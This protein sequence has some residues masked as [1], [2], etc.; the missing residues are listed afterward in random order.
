MMD[1][2][3]NQTKVSIVI[4]VRNAVDTIENTIKS[5]LNQDY[6]NFELVILDGISTDG[7]LA[8]IEKYKNDISYFKSEKDNG[9]YDA[10]NNSIEHCTG[11]YIYFIGADDELYSKT[12]LS[13]IF[14]NPLINDEIIYG[15]AFYIKRKKIRFGKINRY[16]LSKHNFNHQTI[17]YPKSVFKSYSYETKYT[18]W[19]DYYL[20]IILFF[21]AKYKFV[22]V[23]IIVSKFN[24][25][26]TSGINNLDLSFEKDKK[27]IMSDIFP[28]DV[29]AFHIAR[30]LFLFLQCKFKKLLWIM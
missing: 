13:N 30:R 4:V 17:F 8:I 6:K 2:S 21:K 26:G 19:A 18:I 20:N 24:D 25:L 16:H 22:Y 14:K 1:V 5:I 3:I 27:K 28:F 15:N 29:Y 11:D 10:M 23:N 9:I 12:V 7:T